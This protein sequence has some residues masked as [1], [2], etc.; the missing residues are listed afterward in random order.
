MNALL[1]ILG[2]WRARSAWLLAGLEL[3]LLAL[4]ASLG[5]MTLA[6]AT[7]AGAGVL[8]IAAVAWWAG[9]AWP[10]AAVIGAGL[11]LSST[12]IVL[13]MLAERDL[14]AST[15]GRDAFSVLLFQDLA[16]IPLVAAVPLLAG[17]SMAATVSWQDVLG[18]IAVA[19]AR[20]P[21]V[22]GLPDQRALTV[23]GQRP[24]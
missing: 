9:A 6:G 19:V 20:I 4:I 22:R 18:A 10:G 2:L 23:Q 24:R 14:L 21:E 11:A 13:P 3:S 5:L 15:A 12:A 8:A 1:R 17:G 7:L 16:F